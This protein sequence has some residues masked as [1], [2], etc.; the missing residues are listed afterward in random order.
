MKRKIIKKLAD[1][2]RNNN[3]RFPNSLDVLFGSLFPAVVSPTAIGSKVQ[4][5]VRGE[6]EEQIFIASKIKEKKKFGSGR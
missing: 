5:N 4:M 6:N 2:M 1:E 3:G